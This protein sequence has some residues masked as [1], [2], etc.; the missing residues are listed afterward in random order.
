M[1]RT[2]LSATGREPAPLPA[3]GVPDRFHFRKQPYRIGRLYGFLC[4]VLRYDT[5]P[6]LQ[7]D[8]ETEAADRTDCVSVSAHGLLYVMACLCR[9][10]GR[11]DPQ[12]SLK[13][14][15]GDGKEDGCLALSVVGKAGNTL[16]RDAPLLATAQKVGHSGH[17][18]FEACPDR[19]GAL[20]RF[21]IRRYAA[22]TFTLYQTPTLGDT[23]WL[24]AALALTDDGHTEIGIEED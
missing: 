19:D 8:G 18:R 14:T 15:L 7:S 23:A 13:L 9:T 24:A 6:H 17:F 5:A 1:S 12:S 16:L 20:F 21:R 22:D 3:G 10:A 4:D 2:A 11:I